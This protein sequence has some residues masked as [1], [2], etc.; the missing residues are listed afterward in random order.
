MVTQGREFPH[1][2]RA[3][4]N[5]SEPTRSLAHIGVSSRLRLGNVAQSSGC[6]SRLAPQAKYLAL[7]AIQQWAA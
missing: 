7:Q 4:R 1:S 3:G 2:K 5:A 6:E